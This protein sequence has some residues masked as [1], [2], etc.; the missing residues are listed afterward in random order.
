MLSQ[1]GIDYICQNFGDTNFCCIDDG[2][3]WYYT[4]GGNDTHETGATAQIVG[5]LA[6]GILDSLT[7]VN[8][9]RG[10][11]T[12]AALNNAN[13]SSVSL[14]DAQQVAQHD[15]PAEGQWCYSGG[16]PPTCSDFTNQSLC[17]SNNCFW[18]NNYC[19]S[20]SPTCTMLNNVAD[21]TR[22]NCYWYDNSCHST[23]Y[24]PP[25]E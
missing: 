2:L 18:Y 23:P 20:T 24:E 6:L 10:T 13:G 22:F 21:C 11:F 15:T 16:T 8:P 1:N 7:M 25:P 4:V 9:S 3:E 14:T 5:R 12:T 19:Y 17:E